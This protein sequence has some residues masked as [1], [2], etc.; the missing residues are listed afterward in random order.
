MR[1]SDAPWSS[2]DRELAV[3]DGRLR[4]AHRSFVAAMTTIG[5]I[6]AALTV[7]GGWGPM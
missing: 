2:V 5:A 3:L 4:A 1:S 6:V 7:L